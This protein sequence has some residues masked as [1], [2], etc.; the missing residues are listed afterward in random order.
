MAI[1]A[2][3]VMSL[4]SLTASVHGASLPD[5]AEAPLHFERAI[6]ERVSTERLR[7]MHET[8]AAEPHRAGTPGDARVIAWIA[9]HFADLGL[10]VEIHEFHAYLPSPVLGH[11]ELVEP[12]RR[13]LPTREAPLDA[14]PWTRNPDHEPGWNAYSASGDV[15][16]SPV[17]VNYGRK[18]DF[19]RLAELGIAIEGRIAIARYG[20][21]FRG[22]KAKF[23][24]E[25]GAIGLV[26]FTDPQDAGHARG[27]MWP[28]GGWA[29]PT[30]IQ[31]GSILTLDYPGDPLT[32]G[33]EATLDA[34]RLDPREVAFPTIP[35]QPVG[36]AA[37]EQILSRMDGAAV[38]DES[39]RG[40]LDV[41]YRLTGENVKVRLAVK[42]KRELVRTANVIGT[43]RG[44][45]APEQMV[46]IGSHHDAWGYG[47]SD[48][49][50]GTIATLEAARVFAE[51]ADAG[52][53]PRRSVAFAAWGAEE[54]GIIGSTEWV[55]ANEPTLLAGGVAYI[56]LDAAAF[57]LKLGASAAPAL[58]RAI[59]RAASIVP[60][61]LAPERSAL[62]EWRQRA[63]TPE[64]ELP[65]MGDLGG[66]SDHVG[67]YLRAGIPSASLGARGA[68]GSQY[69]T[70][71]DHIDWYQQTVGDDYESAALVAKVAAAT[72]AHLANAPL[73]PIDLP[74]HGRDALRHARDLQ[75]RA[76]SAG[77]EINLEPLTAVA[78]A[79]V[80]RAAR[81]QARLRQAVVSGELP[82]PALEHI[83]ALLVVFE[84]LWL[85]PDGLTGRPWHRH[86]FAAT[87]PTSGY[88]AWMLPEIRGAIES[89]D[90]AAARRAVARAAG[91]L[92]LMTDALRSLEAMLPPEPTP[93]E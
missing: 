25:A 15:T 57:G 39:W 43:L 88:A 32:P 40:G 78:D 46:I 16:A 18:Q 81:I 37:A 69:H 45:D 62:D 87:D 7:D 47:A 6:V 51:E 59:A 30:T 75:S 10:D 44:S 3:V 4:A 41:Q 80:D 91:S 36:W 76:Q 2:T 85:A 21:N 1:A 35:V 66:G 53:R 14:D 63:E 71:L 49:L 84:R 72:A 11:L 28:K 82:P 89:R 79:Y 12:V 54:Y 86:L 24:Q 27:P 90:H 19:E 17:Y 58:K 38:P 65:P 61:P 92:N 73:L 31:R 23:A 26:I 93:G 56:N 34:D 42:Q 68:S 74:A 67:L 22:Y 52:N 5:H 29:N 64:S 83:N 20:G 55:E 60:S 9:D 70:M 77:F 8:L 48:P 50:A 33:V 13:T